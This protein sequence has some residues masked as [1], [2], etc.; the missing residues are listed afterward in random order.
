MLR[1]LLEVDRDETLAG[2]TVHAAD[3]LTLSAHLVSDRVRALRVWR[4]GEAPAD[5]VDDVDALAVTLARLAQS[6]VLTPDAPPRLDTPARMR[7]YAELVVVPM[8]LR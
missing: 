2:L 4:S 3:V 6:L 8:V 1:Q 7:Q 5:A